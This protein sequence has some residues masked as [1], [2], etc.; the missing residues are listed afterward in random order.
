MPG[1]GMDDYLAKPLTLEQMRT[2]LTKW[3][4]LA[5]AAATREQLSLVAGSPADSDR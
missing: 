5:A 1:G 4:K 2:V 3:L